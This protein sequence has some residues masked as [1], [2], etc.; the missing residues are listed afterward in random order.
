MQ[1]RKSIFSL[2][3]ISIGFL[4]TGCNS[5]LGMSFANAKSK[6]NISY[7]QG[8]LESAIKHFSDVIN[9]SPSDIDSLFKRAESYSELERHNDAIADWSRIIEID[10]KNYSTFPIENYLA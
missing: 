9:T 1:Y 5:S 4:A 3:L 7:K 2:L 10:P 8:D 6:A